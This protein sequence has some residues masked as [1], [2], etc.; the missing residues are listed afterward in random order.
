MINLELSDFEA[1]TLLELVQ[2][3]TF[4]GSYASGI[5]SSAK[6]TMYSGDKSM[7]LSAIASR[8]VAQTHVNFEGE[9][10]NGKR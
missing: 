4:S 7:A 10:I 1:I 2:N 9:G 5:G 3:S 6:D 8:L